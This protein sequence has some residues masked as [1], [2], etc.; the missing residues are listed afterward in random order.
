MNDDMPIKELFRPFREAKAPQGFADRVMARVKAE[1][2]PGHSWLHFFG[3]HGAA[4]RW[5]WAGGL[6]VA[7]SVAMMIPS[8]LSPPVPSP[9]LSIYLADSS[10]LEDEPNLGTQIEDYF[11]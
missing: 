9:D 8:H 7:A 6:A 5:A 3:L 11:L 10:P 2:A 1:L 4:G